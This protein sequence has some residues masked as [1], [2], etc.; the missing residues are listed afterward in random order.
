MSTTSDQEET[1]WLFAGGALLFGG[2]LMLLM[3]LA[4]VRLVPPGNEVIGTTSPGSQ[5]A[6][7]FY[8]YPVIVLLL[9]MGL[10]ATWQAMN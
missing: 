8:N 6:P 7:L 4:G 3:K 2:G 1:D 5:I 9:A 10:Y